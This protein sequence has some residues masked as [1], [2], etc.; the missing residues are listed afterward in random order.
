MRRAGVVRSPNGRSFRNCAFRL[1]L[2]TATSGCC[3]GDARENQRRLHKICVVPA[4][5]RAF[6]TE[7]GPPPP[8]PDAYFRKRG[9]MDDSAVIGWRKE[10]PEWGRHG[11]PAT[12]IFGRTA[13]RAFSELGFA[14]IGA[15]SAAGAASKIGSPPHPSP[16][17]GR[18]GTLACS[19]G[20]PIARNPESTIF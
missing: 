5:T 8:F 19:R 20:I 10:P 7:P 3:V 15:S 13:T 14:G 12:R 4:R 16:A 17:P 6:L 1:L 9:R 11:P 18:F 2:I